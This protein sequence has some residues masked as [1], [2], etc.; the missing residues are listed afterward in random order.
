MKATKRSLIVSIAIL[1]VCAMSLTAASYAWFSTSTTATV[2]NIQLSVLEAS[3]LQIS[4]DGGNTW[5]YNL[6][7]TLDEDI[8]DYSTNNA[9]TFYTPTDKS[10]VDMEGHLPSN[11]TGGFTATDGENVIP[12][13]EIYFRSMKEMDVQMK[14]TQLFEGKS[15]APA[16]RAAALVSD[17][18][19]F[20]FA[21]TANSAES[22]ISSTAGATATIALNAI[23]TDLN[24]MTL[25]Q[26][27]SYGQTVEDGYYYGKITIKYWVEGT[28]DAAINDYTGVDFTHDWTFSKVPENNG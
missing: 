27:G 17:G 12:E 28:D 25:V 13:L 2:D 7:S 16:I 19:T 20:F 23:S 15:I 21:N 24:V 11:Y 5:G 6:S 3:D 8:Y 18:G 9:T 4:I 1:C 14:G 10:G 22:V 26:G